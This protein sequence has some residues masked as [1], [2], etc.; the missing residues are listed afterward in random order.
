M[1]RAFSHFFLVLQKDVLV[2]LR[3]REVLVTTSLFAL[4]EVI[5][6][7]FAFHTDEARSRLFAPGIIWVSI[8]FAASLGLS[9]L[10][11]R[12]R[13]NGALEGL[14]LSP[15]SPVTLYLA[16]TVGNILFTFAMELVAIP[17]VFLF[18][19]P[20]LENVGAFVLVVVLG[21]VG[22]CSIGTLFAAALA[23]SRMGQVLLPLVVYPLVVP[24]VIG[25]VKA[26]AGVM[27]AGR[28][29]DVWNWAQFMA[30]FDVLF[31]FLSAWLF[32]RLLTEG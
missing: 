17:M 10:F 6:F 22:F 3:T 27:G 24:V 32:E 23:G 8:L 21:T 14:M 2:E 26:T 29:E 7:S 12:E 13:E 31:L 9:R 16:K 25:G 1:S 11:E 30:G 20:P 5:V 19:S 18:F 15:L 28:P 4:L